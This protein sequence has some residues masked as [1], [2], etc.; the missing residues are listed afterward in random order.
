V[1]LPILDTGA[2]FIGPIE[3]DPH[4]LARQPRA[5]VDLLLAWKVKL[6]QVTNSSDDFPV[7]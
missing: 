2:V 7:T 3:L 6:S 5:S 4:H 1:E